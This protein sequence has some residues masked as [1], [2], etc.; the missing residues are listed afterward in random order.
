MYKRIQERMDRAYEDN[1]DGK[2]SEEY[3]ERKS[4][5]WRQA[6]IRIR[7]SM[8]KHEQANQAYFEAG[9]HI[10]H[11]AARAYDLW[12]QQDS[13]GKTELLNIVLSNCTF[14]GESLRATYA[15]PF[16]WIAEG[17]ERSDWLPQADDL[18][19]YLGSE[20]GAAAGRQAILLA[21]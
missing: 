18:R 7:A 15:K 8:E 13:F 10:L 12:L 3:W 5:E 2:I 19:T 11:L 16:C 4:R 20:D 21:A 14:D 9:S 6:Q 17:R 1:V